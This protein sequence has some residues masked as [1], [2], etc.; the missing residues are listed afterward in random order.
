MLISGS[1][2]S[3]T[4]GDAGLAVLFLCLTSMGIGYALGRAGL[5]MRNKVVRSWLEG[6]AERLE[7]HGGDAAVIQG[8]ASEIWAIV[9][10]LGGSS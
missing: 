2:T 8:T 9:R 10:L 1:P 6:L 7:K 5:S 4:E 3:G